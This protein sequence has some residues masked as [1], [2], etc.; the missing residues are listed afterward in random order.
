MS[1]QSISSSL[2][3][4]VQKIIHYKSKWNA[5]LKELSC[6]N[7]TDSTETILKKADAKKAPKAYAFAAKAIQELSVRKLDP[8]EKKTF[9]SLKGKV[10]KETPG[11][12]ILGPNVAEAAGIDPSS[13]KAKNAKP[14]HPYGSNKLVKKQY[15]KWE[16]SKTSKDFSEYLKARTNDKEKSAIKKDAVKYLSAD[17]AEKYRAT[18][19]KHGYIRQNDKAVHKD[20]LYMFV[21]NLEGTKLYIGKKV[22]GTFHHSS[23]LSGQSVQ[24]AGNFAIKSGKVL[25]VTLS[26]GHYHPTKKDGERLRKF[27]KASENMG[28]D[29]KALKIYAHGDKKK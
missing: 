28:S 1:L 7:L 5:G 12:V 11:C 13:I 4:A 29:A 25:G 6:E 17:E 9:E 24:C 14:V 2:P 23:F 15:A 27:L 3:S 21:L 26:S 8:Q 19:D 10:K 20:G 18:F 16:K 22:K